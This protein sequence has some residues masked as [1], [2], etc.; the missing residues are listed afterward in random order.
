MQERTAPM[1]K[2]AYDLDV[3]IDVSD[4]LAGVRKVIADPN[5]SGK[6]IQI[7]KKVEKALVDGRTKNKDARNT[8]ELLHAGLRDDFN[9]IF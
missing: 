8:T 9:R 6:K 2:D 4:V 5:A 1:Y 3:A 7:Y